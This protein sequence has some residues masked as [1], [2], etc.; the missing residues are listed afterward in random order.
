MFCFDLTQKLLNFNFLAWSL[1]EIYNVEH[2]NI[3]TETSLASRKI[4]QVWR[5]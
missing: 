4:I 1:T 5:Y 2:H 3:N